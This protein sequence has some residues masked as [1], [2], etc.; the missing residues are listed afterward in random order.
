MQDDDLLDNLANDLM[1]QPRCDINAMREVEHQ[2]PR[3][4]TAHELL[5]VLVDYVDIW[6]ILQKLQL[7]FGRLRQS[8]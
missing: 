3:T 2:G 8:S 1:P 6:I 7:V 5:G 4:A